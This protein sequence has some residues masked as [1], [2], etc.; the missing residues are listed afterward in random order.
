MLLWDYARHEALRVSVRPKA[1]SRGVPG[2]G[3]PKGV[4]DA[5]AGAPQTPSKGAEVGWPEG[6]L[7]LTD[8]PNN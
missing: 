2:R 3:P 6:L 4:R 5:K 1:G 7:E 8:Q